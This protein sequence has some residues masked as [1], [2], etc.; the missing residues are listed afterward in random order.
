MVKKTVKNLLITSLEFSDTHR[1]EIYK[2]T[3]LIDFNCK[4]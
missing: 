3:A 2:L 4:A 1:H